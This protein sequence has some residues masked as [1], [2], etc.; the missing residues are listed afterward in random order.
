[1][2]FELEVEQVCDDG[3]SHEEATYY[4]DELMLKLLSTY[5][6]RSEGSPD[7]MLDYLVNECGVADWRAARVVEQEGV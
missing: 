7:G 5:Y 2:N 1:M 6:V 4:L 3:W